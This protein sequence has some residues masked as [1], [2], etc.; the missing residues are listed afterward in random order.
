M[1]FGFA[2][3][4]CDAKGTTKESRTPPGKHTELLNT[5]KLSSAGTHYG[6]L[7]LRLIKLVIQDTTVSKA[8][9]YQ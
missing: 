9:D 3:L 7:L 1:L 5:Y 4:H 8:N 6:H 2:A